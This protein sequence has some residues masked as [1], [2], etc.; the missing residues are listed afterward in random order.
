M[1]LAILAVAGVL[2]TWPSHHGGPSPAVVA[3]PASIRYAENASKVIFGMTP[4]QVRQLVGKPVKVVGSCWQYPL[5]VVNGP[6]GKKFIT[7][8]RLCF[9][10]GHYS[11][12]HFWLN[13]HWGDPPTRITLPG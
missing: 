9:Y 2:L 4:K 6:R 13:G 7:A 11:I 5:Y 10:E 3:S 12:E 8:D 1:L